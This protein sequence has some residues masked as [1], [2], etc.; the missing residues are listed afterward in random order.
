[1][2]VTQRTRR[3]PRFSPL[4]LFKSVLVSSERLTFSQG[5][6]YFVSLHTYTLF[7][8]AE[9]VEKAIQAAVQNILFLV[10][11]KTII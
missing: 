9:A 5:F 10:R 11:F 7:G 8:I 2:S 1:M 4:R 3:A 6:G